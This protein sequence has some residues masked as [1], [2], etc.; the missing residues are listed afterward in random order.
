[1]STPYEDL[2]AELDRTGV[3][4]DSFKNTLCILGSAIAADAYE[5]GKDFGK[6]VATYE[7]P[8]DSLVVAPGQVW[9]HRLLP[10]YKLTVESVKNGFNSSD[11]PDILLTD[12]EGRVHSISGFLLVYERAT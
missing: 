1:M 4:S 3:I 9:Q 8:V 6:N 10:S 5:R 7:E 11:R 12:T 2:C